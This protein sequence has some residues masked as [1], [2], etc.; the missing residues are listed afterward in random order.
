MMKTAAPWAIAAALGGFLT[1]Q[2]WLQSAPVEDWFDVSEV[3]AHP[4][5]EGSAPILT[6]SRTIKRDFIGEWSVT[7][8]RLTPEGFEI[9]CEATGAHQYRI[10]SVL[11]K[12]IDLDWWTFPVRC[13][14][15]PGT[16]RLHTVWT[17]KPVGYPEKY[18]IRDSN[19]FEVKPQG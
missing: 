8:R 17:V 7:V 9:A 14:L 13:E 10:D 5:V 16:Y 1:Y 12:K 19:L 18:L 15:K 3:V 2:N 6:V 4:S 11:P